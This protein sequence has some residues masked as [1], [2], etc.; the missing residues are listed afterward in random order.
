MGFADWCAVAWKV[1]RVGINA[2]TVK[3]V[4]RN[5]MELSASELK[6]KGSFKIGGYMELKLKKQPARPCRKGVNPVTKEP[7]VF[8]PK[9]AS[10]TVHTCALKK[11][12]DLLSK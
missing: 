7:C 11:F 3:A 2:Y 10:M 6:K 9:P 4:I 1:D 12:L 8:K 5:Y